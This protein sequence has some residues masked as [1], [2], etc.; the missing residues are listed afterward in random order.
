MKKELD[1]LRFNNGILKE[2]KQLIMNELFLKK[3]LIVRMHKELKNKYNKDDLIEEEIAIL[4]RQRKEVEKEYEKYEKN[5][6]D[7]SVFVKSIDKINPKCQTLFTT[8]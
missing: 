7:T 2:E 4:K 3:D 8:Q 1:Q 5:V 6:R